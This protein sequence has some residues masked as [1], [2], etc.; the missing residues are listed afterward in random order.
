V[1]IAE[2]WDVNTSLFVDTLLEV[3]VVVAGLVERNSCRWPRVQPAIVRD[4]PVPVRKRTEAR[5]S[6]EDCG[7]TSIK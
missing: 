3:L 4:A 7:G 2:G 5:M 1:A 6:V